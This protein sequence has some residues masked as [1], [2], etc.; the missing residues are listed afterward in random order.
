V[1]ERTEIE[2]MMR[3]VKCGKYKRKEMNTVFIPE[4]VAKGKMCPECKKAEEKSI[5]MVCP[6]RGK[7]QLNRSWWSEEEEARK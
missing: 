7:V 3:E 4:R 6:N 1:V 2:K 5:N